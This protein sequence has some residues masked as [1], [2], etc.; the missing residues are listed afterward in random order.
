[1]LLYQILA[2]IIHGKYKKSHIKTINI[3]ISDRTWRKKYE[4]PDESY[5]ASDVQYYF[6]YI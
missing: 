5:S 4:L 1:M 3:K 2:N 6:E